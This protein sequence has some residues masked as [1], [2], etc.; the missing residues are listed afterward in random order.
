MKGVTMAKRSA[1]RV[2]LIAAFARG[3]GS[4]TAERLAA[5]AG[6]PHG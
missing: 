4:F 6:G 5:V 1:G 2:A 3:I